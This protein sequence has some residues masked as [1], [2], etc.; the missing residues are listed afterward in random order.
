MKRSSQLV[1]GVLGL[2]SVVLAASMI[3]NPALASAPIALPGPST[4]P[5]LVVGVVGAILMARRSRRK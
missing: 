5:I 2:T 1:C 4:L 3:A